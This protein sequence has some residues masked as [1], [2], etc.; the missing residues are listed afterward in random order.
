MIDRPWTLKV[1]FTRGCNLACKFCPI[2]ASPEAYAEKTYMEPALLDAFAKQYGEFVPETRIELTLRGEPTLNDNAPE[3]LSIMRYRIPRAQIAMFTNGVRMLKEPALIM[4]LFESGL[5]ILNIDCYNGTYDRFKKLAAEAVG[6]TPIQVHDFREFSAYKRHPNGHAIAAVTLVPDIAD[7]AH[8]VQ[9]RVIHNNAGNADA[10]TLQNKFG[11]P[12]LAQ[13]L[14]KRCARPFR[15]FVL[16]NN[17][18]VVL[19]CH[20]WGEEYVL[21]RFPNE[22]VM[23]I[24]YGERHVAALRSLYAKDRSGTPC[25]KCDYQGGFRLGLLKDPDA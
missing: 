7:P 6:G 16:Y 3:L 17:G 20:D 19:C 14:L 10:E 2:Y 24:W 9:V 15:E 8:L 5:N 11:V 4:R 12:P 22:S 23:D 18:N 1:E 13:T 25:N 21:G